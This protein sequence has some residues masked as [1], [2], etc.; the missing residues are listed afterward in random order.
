LADRDAIG[1]DAA[2]RLRQLPG[3]LRHLLAEDV[4]EPGGDVRSIG[5]E[6]VT[7]ALAGQIALRRV[8]VRLRHAGH[9]P[10]QVERAHLIR[11]ESGDRRLR[12]RE[13]RAG[14]VLRCA[15]RALDRAAR[16]RIRRVA[17]RLIGLDGLTLGAAEGAHGYVLLRSPTEYESTVTIAACAT[18][19]SAGALDRSAACTTMWPTGSMRSGLSSSRRTE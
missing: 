4:F 14:D 11:R 3:G 10:G 9:L 17:L 18:V 12:G 16:V 7:G 6:E 2:G 5:I 19:R 13:R 15:E 8:E 1:A